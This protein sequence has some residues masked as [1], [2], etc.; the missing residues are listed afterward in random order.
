MSGMRNDADFLPRSPRGGRGSFF[1][2]S[3][4]SI[5]NYLR[6]VSANASSIAASTVRRAAVSAA[7]NGALNEDDRQREQVSNFSGS[8]FAF[9][10]KVFVS[11]CGFLGFCVLCFCSMSMTHFCIRCDR[12]MI[13]YTMRALFAA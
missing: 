5:S 10:L 3:I 4:R 11:S 7:S 2:S 13:H 8:V 9:T 1:P 6:S 12:S